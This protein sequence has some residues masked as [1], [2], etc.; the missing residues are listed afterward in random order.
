MTNSNVYYVCNMEL[1]TPVKYVTQLQIV[2][3]QTPAISVYLYFQKKKGG[4]INSTLSLK[5]LN[6]YLFFFSR[7]IILFFDGKTGHIPLYN[8][9]VTFPMHLVHLHIPIKK[10]QN[11]S[12]SISFS[13]FMVICENIK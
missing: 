5:T 10:M 7:V 3:L 12:I 8:K 11:W 4:F 13:I 9:E 6:K 2:L 1:E